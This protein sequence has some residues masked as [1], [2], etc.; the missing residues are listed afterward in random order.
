MPQP[1]LETAMVRKQPP[2]SM[3]NKKPIWQFFYFITGRV[4]LGW[5]SADF[6]VSLFFSLYARITVNS[7]VIQVLDPDHTTPSN[8]TKLEHDQTACWLPCRTTHQRSNN[9]LFFLTENTDP[10]HSANYKNKK[11]PPCYLTF[12]GFFWSFAQYGSCPFPMYNPLAT[13]E[14]QKTASSTWPCYLRNECT[15]IDIFQW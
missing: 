11:L 3:T 6:F 2:R 14:N 4:R 8:H 10:S 13:S 12:H 7:C 9:D 1:T 5:G 15:K